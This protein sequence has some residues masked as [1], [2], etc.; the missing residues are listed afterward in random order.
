MS[1]ARGCGRLLALIY[2]GIPGIL[3]AVLGYFSIDGNSC[4]WIGDEFDCWM[5]AG[6]TA[7]YFAISALLFAS[8]AALNLIRGKRKR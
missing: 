4:D 3:L 8:L 7:W 5:P 1:Q 6:G 2:L